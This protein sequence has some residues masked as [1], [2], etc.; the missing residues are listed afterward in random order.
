MAAVKEDTFYSSEK[1]TVSH[2]AKG[3]LIW[4]MLIKATGGAIAYDK[5]K[6]Q[7]LSWVD[8]TFPLKPKTISN[9]VITLE[10]SHGAPSTIDKLRIDEPNKGLG[11]LH[12][13]MGNQEPEFNHRLKQC[14][15][16]ASKARISRFTIR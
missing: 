12:A 11:C 2:L 10:D 4:A 8:F 9:Q 16:L 1:Q 5:S 6:W 7:I 13:P 15:E 3:A 14:Q